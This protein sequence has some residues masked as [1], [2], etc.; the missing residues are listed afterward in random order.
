MFPSESL[1]QNDT[2]VFQFCY[3][4]PVVVQVVNEDF[5]GVLTM[6]RGLSANACR[7]LAE[8]YGEVAHFDW[9]DY[10]MVE[11]GDVFVGYDLRVVL[12]L[13]GT[14]HLGVDEVAVLAEDGVPLVVGLGGELFFYNRSKL[15]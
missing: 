1:L 14:L 10:R 11:I 6:L 15:F 5:L 12:Q 8:G 7:S 4:V 2:C 13:V 9:P 3:V